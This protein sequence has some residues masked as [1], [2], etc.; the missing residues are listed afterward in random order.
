MPA[1]I[2]RC[3]RRGRCGRDPRPSGNPGAIIPITGRAIA[4]S[5]HDV[6]RT[7][8]R[9]GAGSAKVMLALL[10][11]LRGTVLLYQGEE[12]GLPEVDLR[13]DQLRDPVGDL[14]YPLFKGRDGC[15][16]PMPWDAQQ[17]PIS[18]SPPARPGCRWDPHMPPCRSRR[19][20]TIPIPPWL[21]PAA[22]LKARKE[23]PSSA[24]WRARHCWRRRC[25]CS[26]SARGEILCVFN[27][28]RAAMDLDRA[29]E[30]RGAA[31]F[32]HRRSANWP[33]T[34]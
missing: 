29:A 26:H 18:V 6:T 12:L 1:T 15:R 28:G 32:R 17:A 19:R 3:C 22:L 4:F 16:T 30:Q 7:A 2:L 8:S 34:D 9:F 10:F 13:R 24:R 21:S 27:L 31:R 20:S 33:Q 25:P 11:A 23:H 5:N 14:Y